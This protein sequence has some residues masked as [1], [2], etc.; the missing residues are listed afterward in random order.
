MQKKS[1]V[2]RQTKGKC[3]YCGLA[4][5]NRDHFIPLARGG[6]N[7]HWNLVPSCVICNTYKGDRTIEEFR[8]WL[9]Y[10]WSRVGHL[11]YWKPKPAFQA[12]VD[13][14]FKFYFEE[15]GLS[16]APEL[17]SAYSSLGVTN[18]SSVADPSPITAGLIQQ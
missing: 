10:K 4:A 8:G 5:E 2:F 1:K 14:G 11:P 18:A 13:R 17:M 16:L 3:F 12:H 6:Q 15:A 9:R 7:L